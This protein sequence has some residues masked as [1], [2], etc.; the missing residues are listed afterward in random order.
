VQLRDGP[1]WTQLS[2]WLALAAAECICEGWTISVHF[3]PEVYCTLLNTKPRHKDLQLVDADVWQSLEW[4]LHNDVNELGFTFS[5]DEEVIAVARNA[6]EL[7]DDMDDSIIP[8][9]RQ[10]GGEADPARQMRTVDLLPTGRD[11]LV[12]NENKRRFVDL[13]TQ[14]IML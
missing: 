5:V 14:H 7:R 2:N 8:E 6:S 4:M 10:H 1:A 3:T 12:T 9:A 13:K 11:I